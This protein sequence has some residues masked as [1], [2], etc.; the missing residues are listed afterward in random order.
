MYAT[1]NG[2]QE[3][4]EYAAEQTLRHVDGAKLYD[5][6]T[7]FPD[8]D[9]GKASGFGPKFPT[10]IPLNCA[11]H[12]PGNVRKEVCGKYKGH[13]RSSQFWGLQGPTNAEICKTHLEY[14]KWLTR[15]ATST[16]S[17]GLTSC[18]RRHGSG[19]SR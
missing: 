3:K 19:T 8:R 15:N 14:W 7:E 11:G 17:R 16:R 12:I 2:N 5:N 18:Q 9:K 6:L 13:F 4:W 10:M 1:G